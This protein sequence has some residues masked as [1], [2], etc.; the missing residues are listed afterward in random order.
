MTE[1]QLDVRARKTP[2][3]AMAAAVVVFAV[4]LVPAVLLRSSQT[5]VHFRVVD[6][7]SMVVI[8]LVLAGG[9]LLL[10]RPRLRANADGVLV[11]NAF[12]ERGYTWDTV[13]GLSFPD[14]VAWARIELP[15][16]EYLPVLAIQAND[17]EHAVDAVRA[18]RGL[19]T[20][21]GVGDRT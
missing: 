8:G 12:A 11:R 4:F 16:D 5:G 1:W 13:Q 2:R 3:Y 14:G 7:V 17:N 9:A 10:T 20:R 19:Y 6:Q 21:Y 18:F 15:D